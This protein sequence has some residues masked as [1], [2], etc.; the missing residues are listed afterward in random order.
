MTHLPETRNTKVGRLYLA[1]V[2]VSMWQLQPA[3]DGARVLTGENLC[4][5]NGDLVRRWRGGR[6][7]VKL[8]RHRAL[9]SH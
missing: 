5:S 2:A 3:T 4:F 1:G 9:T 8:R 6:A 7:I